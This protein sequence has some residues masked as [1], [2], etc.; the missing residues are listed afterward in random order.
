MS[1]DDANMDFNDDANM[2][3]KEL[4]ARYGKWAVL[5][6]FA[7]HNRLDNTKSQTPEQRFDQNWTSPLVRNGVTTGLINP[8]RARAR[9]R[10]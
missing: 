6:A 2:D 10:K 7:A 9:L 8:V 3:F 4:V 5:A 1:D